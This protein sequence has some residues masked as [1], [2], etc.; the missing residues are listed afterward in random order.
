M[1]IFGMTL[2][3]ALRNLKCSS[4][5]WS[6][7][8]SSLPVTFRLSAL[9]SHAV[10][11]DAVIQPS[12]ARSP[13][14]PQ[15]K[16]KCHQA[17]RN[18]PSVASFRPTASCLAT[19]LRISSSSTVLSWA[20]VISPLACLARASLSGAVRSRLPTMSARN[21]SG[22]NLAWARLLS[23]GHWQCCGGDCRCQFSGS[24][25]DADHGDASRWRV[26]RFPASV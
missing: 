4:M 21:G 2:V 26:G 16:S 19:S 8:K 3:V 12:R 11:L 24:G 6:V 25:A 9:V 17:R 10:E 22:L 23:V 15:K 5:G 18:S 20:A 1:V 7:G 14:R 13:C